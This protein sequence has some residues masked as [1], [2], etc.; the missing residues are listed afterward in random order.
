MSSANESVLGTTVTVALV[1][2]AAKV[3][4]RPSADSVAPVTLT[5]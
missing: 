5:W 3:S 4:V 1:W 2:P